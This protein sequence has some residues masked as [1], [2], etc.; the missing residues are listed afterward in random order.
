MVLN[1]FMMMYA[2]LVAF[3]LS[4]ASRNRRDER[5]NGRAIELGAQVAFS[6]SATLAVLLSVWVVMY[7]I[8]YA[9]EPGLPA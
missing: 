8:G 4:S 3:V 7:G 1:F 2:V 9:P 6:A 5:P